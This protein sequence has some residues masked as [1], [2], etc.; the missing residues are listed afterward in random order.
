M[1]ETKMTVQTTGKVVLGVT[2]GI[3]AYKACELS[4]FLTKW[5][6]NVAVI[7]TENAQEFVTPLTFSTLTN[8]DVITGMFDSITNTEHIDI[9]EE[10]DLIVVAPATANVIGKVANGIADDMLTTVI[11]ATK[12][13]VI[14]CPAMNVNMYENPIVQGNIAKLKK[15]GCFFEEPAEGEL[16]CGVIGMGRMAEPAEILAAVNDIFA[17]DIINR[18]IKTDLEGLKVM[19]TAG[20]TREAIDTVRYITNFSTGKMG[21]AIARRAKARGADVLLITGPSSLI[22]PSGVETIRVISAADMKIVVNER[23]EEIDVVIKAAA[24]ADVTPKNKSDHKLKKEECGDAIKLGRTDDILKGLGEIKGDKIL[25]GF[26]A[27]TRDLMENATRKLKDKNLDMIVINDVSSK[28]AGFGT[29]TNEVKIIDINGN[30]DSP[31]L[32]M[33]EGVAEL[34]LDKVRELWRAKCR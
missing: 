25:V 14:F 16:A 11:M 32:M 7:L 33:K 13:P 2:G 20:P 29:D 17:G 6:H 26:A 3:A 21:F 23:F 10:A 30:V 12:A 18:G 5:G 22:P 15:H 1:D 8:N 27:E 9:A 19:V 28:N 4:R 24:V 34:I 31:P